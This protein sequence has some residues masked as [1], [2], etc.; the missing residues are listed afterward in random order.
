MTVSARELPEVKK[1][2][3]KLV[4]LTFDDGPSG[5][6]AGLLDG[7][8]QRG[9]K[10]TFFILGQCAASYPNTVNRIFQEGHQVA[11]HTYTHPI[12]SRS[13]I[14]G[15]LSK[16]DAVLDRC[17]G[18][19]FNYVLR[20]PYGDFNS[21]VLSQIHRPA[22]IW[23][24]DTL[25]WKY[26]DPSSVCSR[27]VN[28]IHDGAIILCHD[29][30]RTTVPG[31]LAAIDILQEQGYEFVTINELYRRR[32]LTLE[33]GVDYW[34]CENTGY[35]YGAAMEP[36]ITATKVEGGVKIS[37]TANPGAPIYYTLDG[38]DPLING[39]VYEGAFLISEPATL[40]A[41][42]AFDLNGDRS[43]VVTMD[44]SA[45][46]VDA[47]TV[48][49]EEGKI[50]LSTEN[51]EA[52]IYYTTDGSPVTTES[53]LYQEPIACYDGVL[54][55]RAAG[56]G[57]GSPAMT[58]YVTKNGNLFWDVPDTAWYFDEVDQAV[59]AGLFN[60]TE[61][62]LFEPE[63]AMTRAMFVTTIYRL[64]EGKTFV[65][66]VPVVEFDDVLKDSW[67]EEAVI[68]A[69]ENGIV[70]GYEDGLFYPDQPIVR[71]EMCV[72]LDR[73]FEKMGITQ[74]AADLDFLDTAEIADWA[75]ESVARLV[76]AEII[77]G[78]N[79]HNFCPKM[80]ATR[81]EV[82][83]ALLRVKDY[84]KANEPTEEPSE[85]D[86]PEDPTEPTEPAEPTEP[87][88]PSDSTEPSEPS[89]PAEPSQPTEPEQTTP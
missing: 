78:D 76:K 39:Q 80:S 45:E 51:E 31:V 41:V 55:F 85:P 5:Y 34:K 4:A 43:G 29:I 26:R 58:I 61:E 50:V 22:I 6:T 59:L 21:Y 23:S 89:Q 74:E 7:L 12:L 10:A 33:D 48:K 60:G 13:D 69:A 52:H 73:L 71:E 79:D 68:W 32:G 25:D 38:S 35:D 67:Y 53:A 36:A 75:A 8:A 57:L 77:I 83:T 30:H 18:T 64:L 19:H 47:P 46:A 20:P 72:I 88:E 28:Y 27:M 24:L 1:T 14:D 2:G 70:N 65:E 9:A 15:E 16:T 44:V 62:Y 82:A 11:Q 63:T 81:A 54:N 37:M 40:R 42:T 87:T 49:V 66:D 84:I 86:D 3:D 17:L 56:Y